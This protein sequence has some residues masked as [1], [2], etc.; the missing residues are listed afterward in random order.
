[1]SATNASTP[2]QS[3]AAGPLASITTVPEIR[4]PAAGANAPAA[5]FIASFDAMNTTEQVAR[6][7]KTLTENGAP[8]YEDTG[9]AIV[10]LFFKT[11]RGASDL[12]ILFAAAAD[13][14]AT[15]PDR[16]ADL[17]IL[18]FHSGHPRDGQG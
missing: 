8:C 10:T 18:A 4:V 3:H 7:G 11:V 2:S 17:F 12:S 5:A 14:A 16:I 15:S 9:E 13:E 1:M 6:A